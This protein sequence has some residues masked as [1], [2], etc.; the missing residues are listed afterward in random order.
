VARI[1]DSFPAIPSQS[2][3]PWNEW[4]DG[5]VWQLEQGEDFGAKSKTFVANARSQAKKRGGK[6]R[7]RFLIEGGRE[8]VVLQF[9]AQS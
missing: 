9:R 4:L 7:T 8:S 6:V 1:L 3:H 2:R 5:Q